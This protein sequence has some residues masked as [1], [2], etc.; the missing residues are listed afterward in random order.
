MAYGFGN[1]AT[2]VALQTINAGNQLCGHGHRDPLSAGLPRRGD[3]GC[4]QSM[5]IDMITP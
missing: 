4:H 2:S 5:Q 1:E 3:G